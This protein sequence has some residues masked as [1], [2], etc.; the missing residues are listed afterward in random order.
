[1]GLGLAS[2]L[3]T[4]RVLAAAVTEWNVVRVRVRVRVY[5]VRVRVRV[6]IRVKVRDRV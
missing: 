1:M 3:P 6:R 2:V 5:G 4:S